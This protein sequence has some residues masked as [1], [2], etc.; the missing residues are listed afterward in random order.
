MCR[1]GPEPGPHD[2]C[3]AGPGSGPGRHKV[4]VENVSQTHRSPG[5]EPMPTRSSSCGRVLKSSGC[6][7]VQ[8]VFSA[9][10]S[11]ADLRDAPVRSDG[12]KQN[13]TPL[14]P[15]CR[16]GPEPGPHNRC[17]AGPGSSPGRR[18]CLARR[19]IP[20]GEVTGFAAGQMPE[21]TRQSL[22]TSNPRIFAASGVTALLAALAFSTGIAKNLLTAM[23]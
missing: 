21:F 22:R 19:L 4:F 6:A 9:N 3:L 1:P 10:E 16:P 17:L 12:R 15:R 11:A 20:R 18:R 13:K 14:L 7:S 8:N 23:L 2:R 5:L